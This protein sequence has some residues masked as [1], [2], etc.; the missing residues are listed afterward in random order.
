MTTFRQKA[1][2]IWTELGI[3]I[4]TLLAIVLITLGA[5]LFLH[6]KAGNQI[7]SF[8]DSIEQNK[9]IRTHSLNICR[10][11]SNFN[12]Q[13]KLNAA[14]VNNY[15]EASKELLVVMY[16]NYMPNVTLFPIFTGLVGI[17]T[18]I[19]AQQSWTKVSA[20]V[21]SLFL[22]FVLFSGLFGIYPDI[23]HQKETLDKNLQTY[24]EI[25]KMQIKASEIYLPC[26]TDST[27]IKKIIHQNAEII[28]KLNYYFNVQKSGLDINSLTLPGS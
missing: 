20:G 28:S 1:S 15:Q 27:Q 22:L 18:L 21:K 26:I 6:H 7:S 11:T 25:E 16:R 5:W 4:S 24:I 8:F 3:E 10:D 13:L 2:D 9:E 12:K 17:L 19:I 14:L 23:F